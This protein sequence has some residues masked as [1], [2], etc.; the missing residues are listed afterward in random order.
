MPGWD[1]LETVSRLHGTAQI[2]GLVLLVMLAGIAAFA[3]VNLRQGF[4]VAAAFQ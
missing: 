3:A 4:L 1:S 2:I